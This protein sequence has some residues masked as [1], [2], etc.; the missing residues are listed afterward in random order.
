VGQPGSNASVA[1]TIKRLIRC[2]ALAGVLI[3]VVGAA[4]A[5]AFINVTDER[6]GETFEAS[7]YASTPYE[8]AAPCA[9]RFDALQGCSGTV[10]FEWFVSDAT[11]IIDQ[12][13]G[14]SLRSEFTAL[15]DYTV[16]E[17]E[18]SG[19]CGANAQFQLRVLD[20]TPPETTITGGPSAVVDGVPPAFA[21][22]A[23][24]PAATFACSFDGAALA[25]CTSPL[26]APPLAVAAHTFEVR[27]TD[28]AGNA[29]PTPARLEFRIVDRTAPVLELARPTSSS[30]RSALARGVTLAA[31]TSE[32]GRI[33]VRLLVDRKTAR[34]LRI[35]KHARGPVVVGSLARDIAVGETVLQ[36][37]LSRGARRRLERS[38]RVQLGVVATLTD[39]AGNARTKTLRIRLKQAFS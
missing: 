8:C 2:L 9:L 29:D 17:H 26:T 6:T 28:A 13:G 37:K 21:F 3:A 11:G 36:V 34:R 12:R 10:N 22:T 35:K 33:A 32:A 19:S 20:R 5:A 18:N 39:P 1:Q 24:E 38:A 23:S 25:P 27:A 15:G 31:K 16:V 14:L 7:P 30:L 4:P